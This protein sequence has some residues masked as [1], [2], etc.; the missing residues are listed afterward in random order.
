MNT[1]EIEDLLRSYEGPQPRPETTRAVINAAAQAR[2]AQPAPKPPTAVPRRRRTVRIL[3]WGLAAVAA[4]L[5]IAVILHFRPSHAPPSPAA[6]P[7]IG[8]VASDGLVILRDGKQHPALPPETLFV[9]DKLETRKRADISLADGSTIR[10]DEGARVDL[11][12]PL[13]GERSRVALAAGRI[14]LRVAGGQGTFVVAGSAEVRVVGTSFGVQEKEGQ[15][16]VN[17]IGGSVVLQS[18]A[19]SLTLE[20]GQS[21]AARKGAPP[22]RTTV[23]PN[24]AVI[25]ARD[26]TRFENQPLANVLDWIGR[27]S[28]FRFEVSPESLNERRVSIAIMDE[29]MRQIVE[30]LA[31]TCGLQYAMDKDDVKI[32]K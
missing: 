32:Q 31:L 18:D 14:F 17:V 28:T 1:R 21:A 8:T 20:R 22:D 6:N 10:L 3:R 16:S 15:T 27:N 5:I 4:C 12:E 24:A 26:P 25:W 29:P 9:N 30:A 19:G 11:R 7:P 13:E 23:D 2:P